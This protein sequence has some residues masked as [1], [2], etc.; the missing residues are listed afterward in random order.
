MFFKIPTCPPECLFLTWAV[1]EA[2]RFRW[3]RPKM[4]MTWSPAHLWKER[5]PVSRLT[6]TLI[7]TYRVTE[8]LGFLCFCKHD[9]FSLTNRA[10]DATVSLFHHLASLNISV[11]RACHENSPLIITAQPALL[12]IIKP[13]VN[14]H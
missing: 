3:Q 5:C 1:L 12:R 4:E 11:Y 6:W 8:T 7:K 13:L 10:P 14:M 2:K 9:P